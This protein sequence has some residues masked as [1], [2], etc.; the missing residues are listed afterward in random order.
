MRRAPAILAGVITCR[1]AVVHGG[2]GGRVRLRSPGIVL[3]GLMLGGRRVTRRLSRGAGRFQMATGG[4][5]LMRAML[6]DSHALPDRH[7][8]HLR[9]CW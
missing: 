9:A 5:G 3:Y 4:D 2:P 7:R 6:G 1:I 8:A